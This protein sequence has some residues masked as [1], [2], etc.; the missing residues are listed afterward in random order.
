MKTAFSQRID[1][2]RLR[3]ESLDADYFLNLQRHTKLNKLEASV[4]ELET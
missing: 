4:Q 2:D 3:D 1:K